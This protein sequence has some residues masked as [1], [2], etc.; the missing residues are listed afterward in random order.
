MSNTDRNSI[1]AA[2]LAELTEEELADI[3]RL[4]SEILAGVSCSATPSWRVTVTPMDS[5]G[6]E[7]VRC[8]KSIR[9]TLN[10]GLGAAREQFEAGIIVSGVT[11]VRANAIADDANMAYRSCHG[12]SPH[13]TPFRVEVMKDRA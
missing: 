13:L 4:R 1:L 2:A 5:T 12:A 6:E 10:N 3:L 8:I 7:L 9:K 11:F